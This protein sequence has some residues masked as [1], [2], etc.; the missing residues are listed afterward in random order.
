MSLHE[1]QDIIEYNHVH[2]SCV[3]TVFLKANLLS[4]VEWIYGIVS[5]EE[6]SV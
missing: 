4:T 5:E 3:I 6:F 2:I 1:R